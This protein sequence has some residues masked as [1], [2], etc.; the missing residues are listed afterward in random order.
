MSTSS[1]AGSSDPLYETDEEEP[2]A[3]SALNIVDDKKSYG[4]TN[5]S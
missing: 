3:E 1:T 2:K 4:A 5:T